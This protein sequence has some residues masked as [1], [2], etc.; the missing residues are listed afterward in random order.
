MIS[1]IFKRFMASIQPITEDSFLSHLKR[2]R[3]E[4]NDKFLIAHNMLQQR[5]SELLAKLQQLEDEYTRRGS[6]SE[7]IEQLVHSKDV[8]ITTLTGNE[9]Q[10]LLAE[11]LATIDKRIQELELKSYNSVSLKWDD[12]IYENLSVIGDIL[13]NHVIKDEVRDYKKVEKPVAV[14]G[15]TN[16]CSSSSPNEFASPDDLEI[17]SA[18]NY[19]YICDGGQDCVKVFNKSFQFMFLFSEKMHQP[20]GIRIL[21]KK[22]YVTQT[23]S[24]VLNI[25]TTEG[26]F[27]ES[28]GGKGDGNLEF[29]VPRGLCIST[30]MNRIYVAEYGNDRVHC[31]NLNLTFHSIIDNIVGARDIE[32]TPEE[33]VVLSVKNPCVYIYS[34][35]HQLIK[36]MITRGKDSPLQNPVKFVLDKFLNILITDFEN[37]CICVYSYRGDYICTIGKKGKQKGEFIHPKG[38]AISPQGQIIVTSDNPNCCVQAF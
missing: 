32:L 38:I 13:L 37:H 6:K 2:V 4:I 8:L 33:V 22:V 19:L 18:T 10:T 34:Y 7:Q 36:R 23:G 12:V 30:E 1:S 29:D 20:D 31:L 28:V 9:N 5:E 25:Y 26:K 16:K 3:F 11:N 21:Q 35:T 14:F 24:D 27:L 17:D 15:T